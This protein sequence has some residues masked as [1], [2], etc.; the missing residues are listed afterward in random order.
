LGL[1]VSSEIIAKH[2]ATVRVASRPAEAL[3][4]KQ[5]GTVFMLF[6]PEDGIGSAPLPASV[7]TTQSAWS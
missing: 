2:K 6:F 3:N 4:G 7:T 5:S 1:W